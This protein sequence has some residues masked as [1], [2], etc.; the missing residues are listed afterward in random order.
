[1]VQVFT[2]QPY[3]IYQEGQRNQIILIIGFGMYVALLL[4]SLSLI[5]SPISFLFDNIWFLL[6]PVIP[7][8]VFVGFT[9]RWANRR[10]R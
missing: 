3:K 4:L 2:Q 10:Y 6:I 1:M 9:I 8:G 5:E 7:T